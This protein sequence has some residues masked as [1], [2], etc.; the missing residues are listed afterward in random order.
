MTFLRFHF[1]TTA[2]KK[3]NPSLQSPTLVNFCPLKKV[4]GEFKQ[5]S[6]AFFFCTTGR[7]S[8]SSC[9]TYEELRIYLHQLKPSY[10]RLLIHIYNF[11]EIFF[12]VIYIPVT[13]SYSSSFLPSSTSTSPRNQKNCSFHKKESNRKG[14]VEILLQGENKKPTRQKYKQTHRRKKRHAVRH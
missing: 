3:E 14:H 2:E 10:W 11:Q 9:L 5:V 13:I 8:L 6:P 4:A 12:T 1:L 7:P